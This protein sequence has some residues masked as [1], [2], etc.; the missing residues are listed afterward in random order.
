MIDPNGS[1][2]FQHMILYILAS[3]FGV[4]LIL[5]IAKDGFETIVLPRRVAR[6]FRLTRLFYALTWNCWSMLARKIRP[7]NRREHYLSFYGPLSLLF[8]L[9]IWAAVLICG[10]ALLQWGLQVPLNSPEKVPTFGTYLYASGVTF[11]TLGYGD[12]IPLAVD[13]RI[14]AVVE[15]GFGLA[16][17]ALVIGYVPVIYQS[18]S[19]R[20]SMIALLDA[21]AGSPPCALELLHRNARGGHGD[22]LV[23]FLRDWEKWCSEILES[24]LSYPVLTY[25]R[26]QHERQSWLAALTM[27]LDIC[28]LAITG[29]D[30]VSLKPFKF[31]FAVARHACVD[32]AQVYG[33]PPLE[34]TKRLTTDDFAQLCA[35]LE[36]AGLHFSDCTT[37]EGRLAKIRG[38]YEPFVI[39]LSEHLLMPLPSWLSQDDRVDDWQTSAWDHFLEASPQTLDR[40]MRRE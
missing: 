25:Y 32:L 7:G 30:G 10:F 37:A 1:E 39:S 40:A 28:A 6:K 14:L 12:V 36:A 27:I 17:L 15:C 24:H 4:L 31:I 21:R 33:T 29:I 8:L 2:Y 11:V 13:G 38:M 19:R 26:S 3:I 35:Q 9:V 23:A 34:T 5:L 20:E 16:F 18:F 22:E